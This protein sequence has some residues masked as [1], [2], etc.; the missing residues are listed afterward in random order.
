[1]VVL[2]G[3]GRTLALRLVIGATL[4]PLGAGA[5]TCSRPRCTAYLSI[6]KT[7]LF[8]NFQQILARI[9]GAGEIG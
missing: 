3:V 6:C 5:G 7:V 8:V 4:P 1:M 9:A 2:G